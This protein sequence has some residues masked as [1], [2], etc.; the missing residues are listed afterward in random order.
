M[1]N[2]ILQKKELLAAVKSTPSHRKEAQTR[3]QQAHREYKTQQQ[4][5]KFNAVPE[6]NC[7]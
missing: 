4:I 7:W 3:Q 1:L 2:L 5:V 6:N